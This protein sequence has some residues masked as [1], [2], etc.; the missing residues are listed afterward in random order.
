MSSINPARELH[1][2]FQAWHKRSGTASQQ[3]DFSST[4][5]LNEHFQAVACLRDISSCLDYGEG[6]GQDVSAYREAHPYWMRTVFHYGR[7]W[8]SNNTVIEEEDMLRALIPL[9]D[10]WG[11]SQPIKIEWIE[12]HGDL[13]QDHLRTVLEALSGDTTL[14]R[15]FRMHAERLII[16]VLD[17]LSDARSQNGFDLAEALLDLRTHMDSAYIRSNDERR[18]E[19][20]NLVANIIQHPMTNTFVSGAL[21]FGSSW[22]LLALE[23]SG[24]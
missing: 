22:A 23:A 16:H 3:R 7:Q 6:L 5:V 11:G 1:G 13:L 4:E 21:G 15:A 24:Q 2:I 8:G 12:T 14:D 10:S 9:L 20:Y 17:M 19:K 18:R